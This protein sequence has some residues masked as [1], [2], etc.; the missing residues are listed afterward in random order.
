[1]HALTCSS[2]QSSGWNCNRAQKKTTLH[3][4]DTLKLTAIFRHASVLSVVFRLLS[5]NTVIRMFV[6][7]QASFRTHHFTWSADGTSSAVQQFYRVASRDVRSTNQGAGFRRDLH[8][9]LVGDQ[10]VL[11]RNGRALTDPRTAG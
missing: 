6:L 5:D 9:R 1:M 2:S 10:L 3:I 4:T 8:D 11:H 7:I